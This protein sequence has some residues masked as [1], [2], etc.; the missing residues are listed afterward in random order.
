MIFQRIAATISVS[1]LAFTLGL[2]WLLLQSIAWV[3]M[4]VSYTGEV[5]VYVAV[6]KALDVN[7]SCVLCRVVDAGKKAEQDDPFII[8]A[9]ELEGLSPRS[10]PIVCR[11]NLFYLESGLLT[12]F[13]S[14]ASV[15]PTPPPQF[16]A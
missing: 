14:Q 5:P 1:L 8:F 11:P 4:T 7:T 6:G 10:H 13:F 9:H 15:P 16:C 3:S 12:A 2:H